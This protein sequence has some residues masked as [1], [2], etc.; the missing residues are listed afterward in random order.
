MF[1]WE[2]RGRDWIDISGLWQRRVGRGGGKGFPNWVLVPAAN[3]SFSVRERCRAVTVLGAVDE[4]ALQS[5][6]VSG[7]LIIIYRDHFLATY[8]AY[9]QPVIRRVEENLM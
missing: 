2:I 1:G 6:I 9:F 8:V 3:A 7:L 4:L 5:S